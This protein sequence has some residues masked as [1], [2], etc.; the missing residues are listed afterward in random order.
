VSWFNALFEQF[1]HAIETDD[2]AGKE[3]QEAYRCV[4]IITRAYESAKKGCSELTLGG[5]K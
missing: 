3:A 4:E 2:Y 1:K 5:I